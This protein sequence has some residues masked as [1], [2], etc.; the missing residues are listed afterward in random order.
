VDIGLGVGAAAAGEEAL[1][2]EE[3]VAIR[4]AGT[5]LGDPIT[6]PGDAE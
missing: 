5:E 4:F 2:L 1:E 6:V 3:Y